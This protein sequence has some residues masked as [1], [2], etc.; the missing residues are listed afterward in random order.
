MH[1][2]LAREVLPSLDDHV[3]KLRIEFHQ[4]R[5]PAGLFRGDKSRTRSPEQ[6]ENEV[7]G[8]AAVA[9][10]FFSQG[11]WFLSGMD[12][13]DLSLTSDLPDGRLGSVVDEVVGAGARFP[14]VQD[15][16]VLGSVILPTHTG[17]LLQ[18]DNRCRFAE[19]PRE[20]H[21]EGNLWGTLR[22]GMGNIDR[23]EF[24]H[25]RG[26]TVE[27]STDKGIEVVVSEVVILNGSELVNLTAAGIGDVVRWVSKDEVRELP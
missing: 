20:V 3:A 18:P 6:V 9:Q 19:V 17:P 23:C 21:L 4:S 13:G 12:V 15:R 16:L 22:V 26:A 24:A 8:S 10:S 5:N 27:H 2:F 14:P 25:D 11:D 7:T 1:C